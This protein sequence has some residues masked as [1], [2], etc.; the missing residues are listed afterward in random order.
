MFDTFELATDEDKECGLEWYRTAHSI[1][2]GLADDHGLELEQTAGIIAALSPRTAWTLNVRH[3]RQMVETGDS[4][5]LGLGRRKAQRILAGESPSVVLAPPANSPTSGQKVRSFYVNIL[6]PDDPVS[7]TVDQHAWCITKGRYSTEKPPLDRVGEYER[8]AEVYRRAGAIMELLPSQV[9]AITW[10]TW[11][12]LHAPER[13]RW[14][15]D[16]PLPSY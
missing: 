14:H 8:V 1:A 15:V 4:P 3:A 6:N 11:R 10:T 9:Q 5:G 16:A 7:V 12:R 13:H 2:Q